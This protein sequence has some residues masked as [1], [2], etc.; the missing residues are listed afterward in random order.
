MD[1]ELISIFSDL[2]NMSNFDSKSRLRVL[3]VD[4][5]WLV[6][7][8]LADVLD[9]AGFFTRQAV[10]AG[11]ALRQLQRDEAIDVVITDI[12]MPGVLDGLDLARLLAAQRPDVGVL[13]VSGRR[14]RALP[15][16]TRF[17]AKPF[18]PEE[19]LHALSDLTAL[20]LAH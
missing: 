1:T 9:E 6:R 16:G 18:V 3:V 2:R 13:I 5:E 20:A 11:E 12:E 15:E 19:L 17:L 10:S 8:T 7:E 4:D 14:P